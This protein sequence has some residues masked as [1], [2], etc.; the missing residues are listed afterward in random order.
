MKLQ[1]NISIN[2]SS[3]TS[4]AINAVQGEAYSRVVKIKLMADFR[5]PWPVP[6]GTNALITYRKPDG[7]A[8]AYDTLP[9]GTQAYS[10]SGNVLTVTIA[11]QMLTVPGT[12][13]VQ[14]QLVKNE[15]VLSTFP[16][17]IN[18]SGSCAGDIMSEDYINW[19]SQYLPQVEGAQ[20]GKYLRITQV[21]EQ[22]RVLAI[23]AAD[24]PSGGIDPEDVAADEDVATMLDDIFGDGSTAEDPDI[25]TDDEVE[26]LLD[27]IFG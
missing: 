11:P 19:R 24:A 27:D 20:I 15:T 23:E 26:D 8:G 22:G 21:D 2:L 9:D 1:T 7:T 6:A 16:F 3:P 14:I 18:V 10:V 4:P 13:M 17:R 5:T 12:V 25:A